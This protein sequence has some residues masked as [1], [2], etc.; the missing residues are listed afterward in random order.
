MPLE[1]FSES[2]IQ[3]LVL[4]ICFLHKYQSS[5][6]MVNPIVYIGRHKLLPDMPGT[7]PTSELFVEKSLIHL[8]LLHHL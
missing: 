8:H 3:F 7:N 6:G 5:L 1:S 4:F 2:R